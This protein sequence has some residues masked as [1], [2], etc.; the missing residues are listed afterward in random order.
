MIVTA[1]VTGLSERENWQAE[2]LEWSWLRAGQPG[3][4]LRLVACG[5]D[6]PLPIHL[7]TRVVRLPSWAD[8]PYL[9]R[10]LPRIRPAGCTAALAADGARRRHHRPDRSGNSLSRGPAR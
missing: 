4:L 5:K 9:S 6:D 3:E 1:Y 10:Q 7:L 2:L 8:H